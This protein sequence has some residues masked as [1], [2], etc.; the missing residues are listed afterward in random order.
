MIAVADFHAEIVDQRLHPFLAAFRHHAQDIAG[1][2]LLDRQ[3]ADRLPF[4]VV[5]REQIRAGQALE[6]QG[7]LPRE[8]VRVL[9]A[10]IAAEAAHRRHDMRGIA[11]QKHP[12]FREPLGNFGNRAPRRDVLDFDLGVRQ[13]D[14]GMHECNAAFVGDALRHVERVGLRHVAERHHREEAGISGPHQPEEAAQVLIEDIDHAE[15]APAQRRAAIGVKIDRDALC[16]VAGPARADAEPLA[17]RAAIAVGGDH[18]SGANRIRLAGQDV[19]DVAGDAAGVLLERSKLGGVTQCRSQFFGTVTNERLEALLG[20]E[21]PRRRTDRGHAF[22][23]IGDVGGDLLAGEQLHRID[24]AVGIELFLRGRPHP[25]LKPDRPQHFQG[26][27]MKMAGARVNGGAVMAL[28][29]QRLHAMPRQERRRRKPNQT[30]ADDKDVSFDHAILP[31][32]VG[33]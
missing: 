30:A 6:H 16:E 15:I 9:N 32:A 13:A 18:V 12:A 2:S 19:A 5:G 1:V 10:G 14:G 20:H 27:E 22:V 7:Q 17:D 25:S 29:R 21:Q 28:D 4:A 26:A 31:S 8:I 33:L 24:A 23:E 11:D 3:F